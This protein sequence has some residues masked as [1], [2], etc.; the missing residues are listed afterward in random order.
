MMFVIMNLQVEKITITFVLQV[1]HMDYVVS[2][3]NLRASMFSLKSHE[4]RKAIIAV[5]NE[6]VI[7]EFS[8]KSGVKIGLFYFG[9]VLP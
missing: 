8:P 3:A 9:I 5:I 4:N 2:T 7:P 6:M 1:T